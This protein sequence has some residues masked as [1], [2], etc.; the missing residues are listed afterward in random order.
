MYRDIGE[1]LNLFLVY[2]EG[3][4]NK[5]YKVTRKRYSFP[6]KYVQLPHPYQTAICPRMG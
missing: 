1:E 3:G 4:L 5:Q 6:I 2:R